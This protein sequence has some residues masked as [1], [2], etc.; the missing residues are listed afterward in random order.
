VQNQKFKLFRRGDGSKVA[1]QIDR[2]LYVT[3]GDYGAT[4]HFGGSAQVNV[5][6]EFDEVLDMLAGEIA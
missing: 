1:C 6:E 3:R 5:Q 4:L 2:V